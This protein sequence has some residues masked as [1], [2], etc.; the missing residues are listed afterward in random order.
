M[1]FLRRSAALVLVLLLAGC[2]PKQSTEPIQVAHLLPLT[3]PAKK[4]AEEAQ[5]GMSLALENI[6]A[7]D[8]RIAG[9]TVLVRFIDSRG[10]PDHVQ[11]EAVRLV[12]VNKVVAFVAGPDSRCAEPLVGTA[13]KYGVPVVVPCDVPPETGVE[14]FISLNV[15]PATRGQILA[16]YA[17][18][19]LKPAHVV[20]LTDQRNSVAVALAAAFLKE[21]PRT[22][23]PTVEE[24]PYH[25][26]SE[27][28]E[29]FHT[30]ARKPPEVAL[31]AGAPADFLTLA[32]QLQEEKAKLTLLYG[33]EDAGAGALQRPGTEAVTATVFAPEGLTEKGKEF[34]RRYREQYHEPPS[35][36]AAQAYDAGRLLFET[37][38]QAK[39]ATPTRIRDDLLKL[40]AFESVTG[41]V[42]WKDRKPQRTVF[43]VRVKYD[44]A[45]VVQTVAPE[46]GEK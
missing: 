17:A 20:V 37:M 16:R 23:P 3:G 22:S 15:P 32:G 1:L 12:T 43:V 29:F 34:A 31:F 40:D 10:D 25:N 41:K 9:R 27:R 8:Q 38:Q 5:R 39:S 18:K 24:W 14:G 13:Q 26:D 21:W 33:G 4:S 46:E 35:F 11:R 2:T 30:L 42:T 36:A 28:G 19:E 45:K 6:N 7:E 44:E